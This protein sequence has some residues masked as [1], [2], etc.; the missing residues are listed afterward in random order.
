MGAILG[1]TYSRGTGED[2]Y[3]TPPATPLESVSPPQGGPMGLGP[4]PHWVGSHGTHGQWP[5]P[6]KTAHGPMAPPQG[7]DYGREKARR[8]PPYG[9]PNLH[10][11]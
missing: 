6:M 11:G 9:P 4:T 7:G 10:S 3:T 2:I 1:R 8:A 5:R